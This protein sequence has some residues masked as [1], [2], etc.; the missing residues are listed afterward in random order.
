M[1]LTLKLLN[2]I[3]IEELELKSLQSMYP[4]SYDNLATS[5]NMYMITENA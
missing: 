3:E 1:I 2:C 5:Y 4:Y